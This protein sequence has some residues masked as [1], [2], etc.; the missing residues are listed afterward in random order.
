MFVLDLIHFYYEK[1]CVALAKPFQGL[2]NK[3]NHSIVYS[4][5]E[6]NPNYKRGTI[7][8]NQRLLNLENMS[9]EE[10]IEAARADLRAIA[11]TTIKGDTYIGTTHGSFVENVVLPV[12]DEEGRYNWAQ[13]SK[14]LVCENVCHRFV[15]GKHRIFIVKQNDGYNHALI[16]SLSWTAPFTD[17]EKFKRRMKK[18]SKYQVIFERL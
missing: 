15:N 12:F 11:E 5:Y 16:D 10:I 4:F 7:E 2:H 17:K 1:F 18:V 9:K 13:I 6:L 14:G 8:I 3:L